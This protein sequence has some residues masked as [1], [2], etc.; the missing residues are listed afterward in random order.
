MQLGRSGIRNANSCEYSIR[1][2]PLRAEEPCST[3]SPTPGADPAPR[4]SWRTDWN[5]LY[6]AWSDAHDEAEGAWRTWRSDGGARGLPGLPRGGGPRG[7]RAGRASARSALTSRLRSDASPSGRELGVREADPL[8]ARGR[9]P[10][11]RRPSGRARRAAAR[12]RSRA[13]PAR[14]APACRAGSCIRPVI[15]LLE[16]ERLGARRR[17]VARV[18]RDAEH[19]HVV[20][21]RRRARRG[22]V[23]TCAGQVSW[24]VE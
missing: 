20:A 19:R 3:R 18:D 14:A 6:I 23:C 17:V 12:S 11:P 7:R 1:H 21:E 2:E 10:S 5:A 16:Q 24:Q 15:V 8:A 22:C 13:T 9:R 4:A